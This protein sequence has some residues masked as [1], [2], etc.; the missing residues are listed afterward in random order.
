[1]LDLADLEEVGRR[2]VKPVAAALFAP[3]EI[4]R[5]SLSFQAPAESAAWG[6]AGW[7]FRVTWATFVGLGATVD[8]PLGEA[9][10]TPH[11]ARWRAVRLGEV[12]EERFGREL[13]EDFAVP[14][15]ATPRGRRAVNVWCGAAGTP[16][17]W[18]DGRQTGELPL[19]AALIAD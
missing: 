5:A 13:P 2:I 16:P 6:G 18:V 10:F 17:V 12:L 11:L 7:T 3:G 4:E 15:P 19:S 14:P 1:D 9:G 8:F